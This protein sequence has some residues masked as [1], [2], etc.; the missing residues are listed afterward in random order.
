MLKIF[1]DRNAL[2]HAAAKLFAEQAKNAIAVSGRFTV[3]LAGGETPRLSYET[4]AQEPYRSSVPWGD[5]H[6]FWGDERCVPPDD[7]RSN[8]L[9]AQVALLSHVSVRKKQ[10]HPILSD[11]SPRHAADAYGLE[12]VEF[13]NGQPPSFDLVLLGLGDDGHTASLLPDSASL[14]E[15][16]RWT[17]VAKRPEENFSRVTLTAPI[18]NQARLVVFLVSGNGKAQVLQTILNGSANEPTYPAQLIQPES[19]DL[20]WYV[21]RDAASL[22]DGKS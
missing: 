17:A 2:A 14:Q 8:A 4:L 3:L 13:F 9:L 5:I 15:K 11:G 21:D 19:G 22:L 1:E 10:I 16:L 6:F 20:R 12:L 7:P 18:I